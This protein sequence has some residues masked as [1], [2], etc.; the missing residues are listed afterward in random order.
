[1]EW[2]GGSSDDISGLGAEA[3]EPGVCGLVHLRQQRAVDEK[4][5]LA[6]MGRPV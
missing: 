6:E 4:T 5:P 2:G 3:A 1:M